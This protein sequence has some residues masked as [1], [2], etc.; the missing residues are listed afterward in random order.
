[1][2]LALRLAPAL[3]ALACANTSDDPTT[4]EPA[5][6]EPA[7]VAEAEPSADPSQ[8]TDPSLCQVADDWAACVGKRVQIDG[9]AP[10]FVQQHPMMTGPF[11]DGWKQDY[12][13]VSEAMQIIVLT[14]E[15]GKCKGAM[16]VV[17]TLEG[18]DLGGEPGTKES[19]GGWV[20]REA[21]VTCM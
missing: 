16:R 12:M 21:E 7:V 13:D 18:I 2:R 1:M 5:G 3:L 11:D 4:S 10:E 6:V 19:Y 8:T 15:P 14:K 17:G 9:K 20:V